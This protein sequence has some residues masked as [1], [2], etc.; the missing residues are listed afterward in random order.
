[1]LRVNGPVDEPSFL[2]RT[3]RWSLAGGNNRQAAAAFARCAELA[4]DWNTPRLWLAQSL[5]QLGEFAV[6]LKSADA[7]SESSM[8]QD[9]LGLSRLLE[10]R[11]TALRGLGRT[12]E[13][14]AVLQNFLN[15]YGSRNEVLSTAAVL[16][17]QNAQFEKELAVLDDLLRREIN[18][19]DLLA[20]KGLA[21]MQLANYEGAI[22]TLTQALSIS[23]RNEDMRL[24]RAVAFLGAGRL[25]AAREDYQELLSS[26]SSPRN[27]LF[28]L[29]TVAW[30]KQDTN[31]AVNYYRDFLSNGVFQTRQDQL[32]VERLKEL[33]PSP[34]R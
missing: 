10:C 27:A 14:A 12:N 28:G 15:Q 24:L 29:G 33:H 26:S 9:G 4:P 16:Y 25:D 21:Q 34:P 3:G 18:R 19:P 11:S 20:R 2:L 6:A 5:I 1:V 7:I 17:S 31:L 32:A 23:P 13:A 8:A 30:R 22:T